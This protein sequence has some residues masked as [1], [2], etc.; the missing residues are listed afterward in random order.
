MQINFSSLKF[1]RIKVG[2][3]FLFIM[4]IDYQKHPATPILILPDPGD[5]I[6]E[7][8][9]LIT[10]IIF[11]IYLFLGKVE[12]LK[13][14]VN[15]LARTKLS[16]YQNLVQSVFENKLNKNQH[17]SEKTSH[18]YFQQLPKDLVMKL[19]SVFEDDF[20][21]GGYDYPQTYLDA[22]QKK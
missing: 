18:L 1:Q 4:S 8:F 14:D 22:A 7:G 3:F 17:K 9:F 21:L 12:N 16:M 5:G 10:I 2:T 6:I 11:L 19:Y 15:Y 20:H 13:S